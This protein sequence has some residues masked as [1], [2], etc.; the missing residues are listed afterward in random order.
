MTITRHLLIP[1][2]AT[3][4]TRL[5]EVLHTWGNVARH[6]REALKRAPDRTDVQLGLAQAL[7]KL[8]ENDE[9]TQLLNQVIRAEPQN[10][11]ARLSYAQ[12]MTKLDLRDEARNTLHHVLRTE[13]D[14][15]LKQL[16]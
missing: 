13:P 7:T 2:I 3:Q 8:G 1:A 6:Y 5:A 10:L 11:A 12:H 15:E 9:A 16:Q 14:T 4:P